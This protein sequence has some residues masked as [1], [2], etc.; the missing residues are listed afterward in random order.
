MVDDGV[1]LLGICVGLQWLFD[2]SDRGA[3]RRRA[4]ALFKGSAN[5]ASILTDSSVR[6][7]DG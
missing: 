6:P 3:G 5:A 1:P 7:L 4:S 2:G